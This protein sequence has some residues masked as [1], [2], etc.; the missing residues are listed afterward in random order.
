MAKFTNSYFS[1]AV[2]IMYNIKIINFKGQVK[3]MLTYKMDNVL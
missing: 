2:N 3:A 1:R